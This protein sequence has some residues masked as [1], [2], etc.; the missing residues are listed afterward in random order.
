MAAGTATPMCAGEGEHAHEHGHEHG[1]EHHHHHEHAVGGDLDYGTGPAR[2]HVP[3]MSQARM[4][5]IE[6]DILSKNNAYAAANR[7]WFDERG[8]FALE[9]RVQPGLR[10]D[11]AAARP[12]SC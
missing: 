8:I 12:S 10:Q 1:H 2:A 6:Q 11:H 3:G 7:Q 9:P 4:V 5:R